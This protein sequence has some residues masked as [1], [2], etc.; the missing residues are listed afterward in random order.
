LI[1]MESH[2]G[3]D[4][5]NS[6]KCAGEST[7]QLPAKPQKKQENKWRFAL[8]RSDRIVQM[9]SAQFKACSK[10]GQPKGQQMSGKVATKRKRTKVKKP[11]PR[12]VGHLQC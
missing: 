4:C 12:V 2:L 5:P 8:A 3:E 1:K 7:Y 6:T 10:R 11:E 9:L